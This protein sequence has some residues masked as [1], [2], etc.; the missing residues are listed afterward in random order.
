MELLS[1]P[2]VAAYLKIERKYVYA[3]PV[4]LILLPTI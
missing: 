3:E 1:K 2:K 4:P